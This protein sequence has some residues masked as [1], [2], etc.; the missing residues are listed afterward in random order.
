MRRL[1][2]QKT[3]REVGF[4]TIAFPCEM[5]DDFMMES[6]YAA[7]YIAKY[8]SIIVL[9]DLRGENLFPLL[10][11]R[12]NIYTDP[13]RPM[14]AE[15]GIYPINNP[16]ENSP[17]AITCNFSLT[18]FIVSGEI[19][20][21]RVPT[22]LLVKD[23]EGLSVLTAWAAGKF[24]GDLLGDFVLKCGISDKVA[25]KSIVIPGYAAAI[26]GEMEEAA[27]GWNIQIGPREAAHIPKYLKV[28][29]PDA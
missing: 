28:W 11:E 15:E 18:Y 10:L 19:E 22:W 27:A 16:D 24:S 14:T 3:F 2:I 6:M 7:A 23:S 5:T 13:Q 1:A 12:L 26:S 9:S 21:S 25:H 8:A 17:V 4:P 20:A 29:T